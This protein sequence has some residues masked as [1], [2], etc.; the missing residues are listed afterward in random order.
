MARDW[1]G[2]EELLLRAD[3]RVL[4]VLSPTARCIVMALRMLSR[5]EMSPGELEAAVEGY[6]VPC[7]ALR[8]ALDYLEALGF[9]ECS[10]GSCRLSREGRELAEALG[11]VIESARSLLYKSLE[12]SLSETEVQAEAFTP[13]ISAL[14]LVEGYLEEPSLMP[15]YLALH[16]YVSGLSASVLAEVARVDA[17]A[18]AALRGVLG[19]E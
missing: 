14:G 12:G 19:E 11:E 15:L 3:R 7:R 13:M 2:A 10:G 9:L 8:Q 6:G 5:G 18:Y 1:R 16:L 17:R 4:R